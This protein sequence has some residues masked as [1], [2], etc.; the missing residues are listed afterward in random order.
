[1]SLFWISFWTLAIIFQLSSITTTLYL[2]RGMTHR[3]VKF[4]PVI[5]FLMRVQIWLATGQV[6]LYWVA[7]HRKHHQFTDVEGD[8]H[9]PRLKGLW[10]VFFLNPVYTNV[11][12]SKPETVAKYAKD[13]PRGR[14][15]V[16]LNNSLLGL[17]SG[18]AIIFSFFLLVSEAVWVG[19]L[20]ASVVL[21]A[22]MVLY[23]ISTSTINAICHMIGARNFENT[24]TNIR[25]I[26]MIT[27]GES[28]HNN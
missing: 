20:A 8:P 16:I 14:A 17:G 19:A 28:L 21:V 10:H 6:P 3:S 2:H 15:D 12:G 26:S 5:A 25:S 23:I 9:S 18:I 4:H 7:V 27:V 1:M 22:H 24:A 13:I 11:E